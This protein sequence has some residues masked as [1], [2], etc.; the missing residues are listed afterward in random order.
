MG[1]VIPFPMHRVRRTPEP[2]PGPRAPPP[3]P[4]PEPAP[5]R[6][7]LASRFPPGSL[8]DEDA[9]APCERATCPHGLWRHDETGCALCDCP[10]FLDEWAT[11]K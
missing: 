2:V 10:M 4:L 7:P 6:A 3:K 5:R 8:M 9:G 1:I 11:E